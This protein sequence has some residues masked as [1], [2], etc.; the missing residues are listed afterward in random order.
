MLAC[1]WLGEPIRPLCSSCRPRTWRQWF[2][3]SRVSAA[4]DGNKGNRANTRTLKGQ[5]S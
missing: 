5:T 4:S 2:S 1:S 3:R